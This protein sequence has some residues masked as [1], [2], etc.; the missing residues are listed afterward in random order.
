TFRLAKAVGPSGKVYAV[1]IDE[2]MN[3]LIA[4]RAKTEGVANVEVMLAE[5]NDPNLPTTGVDLIFTVNT[6]HHIE[7]RMAY[8]ANLEKYLQPNGRVA[9][10]DFDRRSWF[11][12]LWSH[13]TPA[14]FIRREME[15]AGYML[16]RDLS[17]LD[18]QSFQIFAPKAPA[19]G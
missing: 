7:D 1:D 12:G 5:P 4:E 6:Y 11:Q 18:R 17:F 10:I 15:Q 8:F 13:Y 16:Q 9:I 14:E 3:D 19:K 2:Q